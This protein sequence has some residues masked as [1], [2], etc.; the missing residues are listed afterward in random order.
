[1]CDE[2]RATLNAQRSTSIENR[3]SGIENMQNKANFPK[4]RAIVSY[5]ETKDYKNE[6]LFL[7]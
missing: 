1:M 3:V 2:Y 7:A 4:N 6:P 5:A